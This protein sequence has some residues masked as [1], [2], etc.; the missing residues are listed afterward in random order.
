MT[1]TQSSI[2]RF[3]VAAGVAFAVPLTA[4]AVN[5]QLAGFPGC[6]IEA[7]GEMARPG[8]GGDMLPPQLRGLNLTEAQRDKVF[9]IMHAQAPALRDKA[10]AARKAEEALRGLAQSPDYSEARLR[11][12]VTGAAGAMA[13]LSLARVGVER[14]IHEVLTP[15]QQ[16]Q[17][18]DAKP[19]EAPMGRP[20]EGPRRGGD[21]GH[22]PPP[23]R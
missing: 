20:D 18:R 22:R 19:G 10:K 1:I 7:P 14:Q 16:K 12:L 17:M 6:G 2:K 23:G 5:G 9:A 11:E 15:E 13:A 21:A 3:L 8:K 4:M